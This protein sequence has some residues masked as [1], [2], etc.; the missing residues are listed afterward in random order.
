MHR[1]S[2]HSQGFTLIELSIAILLVALLA[3]VFGPFITL[4]FRLYTDMRER[5]VLVDRADQ[6]LRRIGRD[7][8]RALP[9]SVRV[10][11]DA[12]GNAALELLR[13]VDAGRYRSAGGVNPNG[14]D[15][16]DDALDFAA[17]DAAFT[18]TGTFDNLEF[19]PAV[20][21]EDHRVAVFP[22]DTA[23]LYADAGAASGTQG[24]ITALDITPVVAL[25]QDEHEV[26]LLDALG[27]PRGFQFDAA[28]PV[29]RVYLIDTAVTYYCEAATGRLTRHSAY[30][31]AATQPMPPAD[32][33][34]A[35]LSEEVGACRLRY[36]PGIEG[37]AQALLS[38]SLTIASAATNQTVTLMQQYRVDNRP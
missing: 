15:H 16:S 18:L 6:A 38:L 5:A 37:G 27:L 2:E 3:G 32:G 20:P 7:V 13:I 28:S 12:D 19:E 35:L 10:Q 30:T 29:K 9:N 31:P 21:L 36:A 17:A 33:S 24:V 25:D 1:R 22:G 4:S 14:A 34:A 8:H 23:G 26:R 11:T